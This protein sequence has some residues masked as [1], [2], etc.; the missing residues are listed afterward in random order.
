MKHVKLFENWQEDENMK[1]G[2]PLR[3]PKLNVNSVTPEEANSL[4]VRALNI[5]ANGE[6]GVKPIMLVGAPGMG[7]NAVANKA[8][9]EAEAESCNHTLRERCWWMP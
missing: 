9:Q 2:T 6:G 8:A 4:I 7:M 5:Q 1:S 3:H